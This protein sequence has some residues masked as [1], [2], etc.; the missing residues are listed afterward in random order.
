VLKGLFSVFLR[1]EARGK[2]AIKLSLFGNVTY[3]K[4]IVL[5]RPVARG[6]V[7]FTDVH[8]KE[9]VT[10]LQKKVKANVCM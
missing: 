7:R 5:A 10:D 9:H 1:L 3:N 6:K 4:H 8:T 2:A